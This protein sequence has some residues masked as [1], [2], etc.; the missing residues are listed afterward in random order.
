[1]ILLQST[2]SEGKEFHALT[3]LIKKEL[4]KAEVLAKDWTSCF[5]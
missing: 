5:S 4:K 3:E 1:M 2:M